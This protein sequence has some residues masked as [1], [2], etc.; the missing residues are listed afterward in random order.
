M[1]RQRTADLLL[2]MVTAFWGMSYYLSDLCLQDL[3]PMN[4]NAFR[5]ISAFLVLGIIFFK[6]LRHLNRI[7]L[8]YS[9][10]IG[11]TLSGTYIFYGYGLLYTSITNAGF[12]C[13]L[14]VVFTPIFA[15]I[16]N[17]TKPSRKLLI[18][19]VMC[20]FGLALLTLNDDFRP[21]LGDILC[22]GVPVCYAFDLLL[23]EKAVQDPEV[24]ALGLGVCQLGVV[25]VITLV[26][27]LLFEQPHLPTTPATW[28][29]AL[30]LGLLCSGVAFVI[31]SVEQQYTSASHVGLIFTLEPV[32][33]AIVAFFLAHERLKPRGYVGMVLM[34]LSL[35]LMEL[36][37]PIKRKKNQS[38][39]ENI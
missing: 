10:L 4:L 13:A 14:P 35:V 15:F 32:F 28:G 6:K 21:A 24:D 38:E 30:F 7:T 22:M 5:F 12:I 16:F 19:L 36:D 37:L 39:T 33:A 2:V 3:P 29:A 31:Q 18:C 23:T 9:L 1:K 27:S 8:R 25:G 26:L 11:L 20:A 17:H 34:L